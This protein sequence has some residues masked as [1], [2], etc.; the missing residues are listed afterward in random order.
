MALN[1]LSNSA[2]PAEEATSK[3]G[4]TPER[5]FNELISLKEMNNDC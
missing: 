2:T 4:P 5:G 1:Q 3:A